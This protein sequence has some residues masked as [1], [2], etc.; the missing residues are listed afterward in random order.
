MLKIKIP[1]T[2]NYSVF[3]DLAENI[4]EE[5]LL[6][7]ID[8]KGS[9]ILNEIECEIDNKQAIIEL[10]DYHKKPFAALTALNF[11]IKLSYGI[12]S[13]EFKKVL[14]KKHGGTINSKTEVAIVLYK[15]IETA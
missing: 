11:I 13:T 14:I 1:P 7:R 9:V 6:G 8:E 3:I 5:W 4:P 12:D 15:L 2:H 10:Q